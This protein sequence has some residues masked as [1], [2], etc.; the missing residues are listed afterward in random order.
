M[1]GRWMVSVAAPLVTGQDNRDTINSTQAMAVF[2]IFM[3]LKMF[4]RGV[5]GSPGVLGM[6]EQATAGVSSQ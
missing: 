4:L 2:A 1:M 5:M 6:A 3:G